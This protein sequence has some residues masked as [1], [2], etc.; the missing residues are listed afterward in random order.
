M[1]LGGDKQW[2]SW[3]NYTLIWVCDVIMM[4]AQTIKVLLITAALYET[5]PPL[6]LTTPTQRDELLFAV[7][8]ANTSLLSR[9][10]Q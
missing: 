1:K 10:E 3:K 7:V 2:G 5:R 8:R 9:P 4:T 6:P